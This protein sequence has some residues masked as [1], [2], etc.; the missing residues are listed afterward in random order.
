MSQ[1]QWVGLRLRQSTI[2][3][4]ITSPSL[5]AMMKSIRPTK[6]IIQVG[7]R[8]SNSSK[9]KYP[10]NESLS[11]SLKSRRIG[12]TESFSDV[13]VQSSLKAIDSIQQGVLYRILFSPGKKQSNTSDVTESNDYTV[14]YFPK[15][16]A[17]LRL[18]RLDLSVELPS[19]AIRPISVEDSWTSYRI[20]YNS[21]NTLG[22]LF[23]G[24]GKVQSTVNIMKKP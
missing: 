8:T 9:L 11:K 1:H 3:P 4:S 10:Y 12:K 14:K 17:A 18:R 19:I 7:F 24:F 15:T 6:N 21:R 13:V 22:T 20:V 2:V 23:P 16:L 5:V